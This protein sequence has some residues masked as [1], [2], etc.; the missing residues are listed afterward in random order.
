MALPVCGG[1]AASGAGPAALALRAVAAV[2]VVAG[3][4]VQV[5]GVAKH[6]NRYTVMFRD[7]VL[8]GLPDYGVAYGGAPARAYWRH[9]GGPE[10][11]RQLDRPPPLPPAAGAGRAG[12][13]AGSGAGGGGRRAT[14]AWATPS[15]RTGALIAALRRCPGGAASPS[16]STPATG[17]TAGAAS[18]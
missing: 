13:R 1:R 2:L 3:V 4:G 16:P 8:P 5:L 18:A 17:I 15:P 7:H 11:G 9:F 10:A 12:G 14:G 6:P